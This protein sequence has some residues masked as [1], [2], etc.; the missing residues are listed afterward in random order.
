MSSAPP[1]AQ[2]EKLPLIGR[3][4]S[5]HASASL[6]LLREL[7]GEIANGNAAIRRMRA[8][9]ERD[10]RTLQTRIDAKERRPEPPRPAIDWRLCRLPGLETA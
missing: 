9:V 3:R 8:R 2:Q 4:V 10:R 6:R 1:R 5:P 7:K